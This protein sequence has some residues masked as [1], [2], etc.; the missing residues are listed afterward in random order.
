MTHYQLTCHQFVYCLSPIP[1]G[2]RLLRK[3]DFLLFDCTK[4]LVG[5]LVPSPEMEPR[6]LCSGSMEP[7]EQHL[8]IVTVVS[9]TMDHAQLTDVSVNE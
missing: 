5:I 1:L 6:P 8:F 9:S 3:G 2:Y 4:Q 7:Q